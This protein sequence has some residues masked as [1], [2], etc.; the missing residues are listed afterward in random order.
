[1]VTFIKDPDGWEQLTRGPDDLIGRDLAKRGVRLKSLAM[2]QAHKKTG[3]LAASMTTSLS[4]DFKGLQVTV[5]SNVKHALMHHEGTKPHII[6]PRRAR[7]LR[8]VQR[9]KIRY[10]Q[11]V[12]HPGSRPN[13]YLTDNLPKVVL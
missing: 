1:M 10:A 4:V 13:R 5:G 2:K 11:R 3:K 7:T 9:G 12:F 6:K 8:F